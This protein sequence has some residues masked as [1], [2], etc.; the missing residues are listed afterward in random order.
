[1]D[2]LFS[3]MIKYVH[4]SL[5][6]DN[7]SWTLKLDTF[8]ELQNVISDNT[9]KPPT[10]LSRIAYKNRYVTHSLPIF[11]SYLFNRIKIVSI[12]GHESSKPISLIKRRM[13]YLPKALLARLSKI[14]TRA[15][16]NEHGK[17]YIMLIRIFVLKVINNEIE[18]LT[19]H[20]R[21]A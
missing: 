19:L 2:G 8:S 4:N 5:T 12:Y 18:I 17:G 7:N 15:N 20:E 16:K 3:S 21:I 11:H 9:Y 14:I 1:M 10:S 6:V 13:K